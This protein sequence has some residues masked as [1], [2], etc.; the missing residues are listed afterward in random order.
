MADKLGVCGERLLILRDKTVMT[1]DDRVQPFSEL[2][3]VEVALTTVRTLTGCCGEPLAGAE[4]FLDGAVAGVTDEQG[5]FQW[6]VPRGPHEL[7]VE[8]HAFGCQ[9]QRPM[10]IQVEREQETNEIIVPIHPRLFIYATDPDIDE[11]EMPPDENAEPLHDPSC[12]WVAANPDHIPD[13]ALPVQG[14]ATCRSAAA[15]H[16]LRVSLDPGRIVP[17]IL[18]LGELPPKPATCPLGAL[19]LQCA[20][21]GFMWVPKDPPPL[22]ARAEELGGCELP[23]LLDCPAALG[24]LKPS[25]IVQLPAGDERCLPLDRYCE[26]QALRAHLAEILG[27][28]DSA[29]GSLKLVRACDGNP[30]TGSYLTNSSVLICACSGEG[31]ADARQKLQQQAPHYP[32]MEQD[33]EGQE[34]IVVEDLPLN[35]AGAIG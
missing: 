7:V 33:E 31:I 26:V 11:D 14:L 32:I 5:A 16:R 9:P 15:G 8:H 21:Q 2:L 30:V 29:G 13:E 23:R 17:F 6:M 1:N 18:P 22:Q 10:V 35:E 20:R 24:F 3:A 19:R 28:T 34:G 12:V 27:E 4:V 25:V